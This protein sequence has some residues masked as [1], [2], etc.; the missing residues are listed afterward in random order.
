MKKFEIGTYVKHWKTNGKSEGKSEV[1]MLRDI[2]TKNPET[3]G[4][5]PQRKKKDRGTWKIRLPHFSGIRGK[6][7]VSFIIPVLFIVL[8]GVSSYLTSSSEMVAKYESSTLSNVTTMGKYFELAFQTMSSKGLQLNADTEV[9]DYFSGSMKAD[10][11]AENTLFRGVGKTILSTSA[12][13]TSI[14]G[15]YVFSDYGQVITSMQKTVPTFFTDFA[16]SAEGKAFTESKSQQFWLGSHEFLDEKLGLSKDNYA[17]SLIQSLTNRGNRPIGYIVIDVDADMV[18]EMLED[19]DLGKKAAIGF[20]TGDGREIFT[21]EGSNKIQLGKEDFYQKSYEGSKES[22]Y[23][24]VKYKGKSYLYTYAKVYGGNTMICSLIPNSEIL[25]QMQSLLYLTFALVAVASIIAIA[26][27][28]YLAAGIGSSI[29]RSN[30]VLKEA[31][32]GNLTATLEIRRK[33]EFHVLGKGITGMIQGMK[34]LIGD[35]GKV[36]TTVNE[37]AT[38][39]KENTGILLQ[40]T[41]DISGAVTEIEQGIAEQ[42]KDSESCML[43]MEGLSEKM[44]HVVEDTGRIEEN[45]RHTQEILHRGEEIVHLLGGKVADTTKI[46]K[47]AIKKMEELDKKSKSIGAIIGAI[48]DIAEQTN[49]LSLNASI[50]AARAGVAGRGFAVVAD[51]IRKLA[52]QSAQAASQVAQIIREIQEQTQS[53]VLTVKDADTI[54]SAQEEALHQTVDVFMQVNTQVEELAK[55]LGSIAS[56]MAQMENLKGETLDAIQSISAT[57]QEAAAA[58]GELGAT[59]EDQLLAVEALNQAATML[60]SEAVLLEDTLSVFRVE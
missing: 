59:A 43:Q 10:L 51:E 44:N 47:T 16:N 12:S 40:A 13:D 18:K 39:V 7:I 20:I 48:N 15:V 36:S 3:T 29:R 22:G 57:A 32:G 17:I 2:Q 54:A 52:E 21:G 56:E 50:E 19:V 31:A 27:G 41:R 49:L 28:T 23:E 5:K 33:D 46:T 35:V 8:L 38:R 11:G 60:E 42:A 34:T 4:T 25:S 24:Y 26:I 14:S 53:T 45:A 55:R 37:S 58:S 1:S 9:K 30:E 6:L